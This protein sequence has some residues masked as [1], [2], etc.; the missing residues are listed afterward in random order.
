VFL[1][2]KDTKEDKDTKVAVLARQPN[3]DISRVVVDSI[4]KIHTTL[5]PGLL[6]TAYEQ[7]LAYEL[8]KINLKVVRQKSIPIWY[9]D[10]K[11]ENA[12]RLDMI[13]ENA[14]VLELKC[15]EKI[16][17]VHTAQMLTYL[18][19]SGIKTGLLVNFNSLLIKDGI[20]RISI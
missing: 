3:D 18:K 1:T 16:L 13:V 4:F 19:M 10:L 15:L 20:R 12:L 6:E 2:T 14:L 17:P 7:C 5:G 9:E 11:I 8:E